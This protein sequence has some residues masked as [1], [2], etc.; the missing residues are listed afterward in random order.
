M[1]LPETGEACESRKQS[2]SPAPVPHVVR[3]PPSTWLWRLPEVDTVVMC[4]Q[5]RA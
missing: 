2:P 1:E 5:V 3:R 4:H